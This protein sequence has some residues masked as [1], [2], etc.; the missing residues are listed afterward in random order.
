M[1][2]DGAYRH[3]VV[4]LEKLSI[5]YNLRS[6]FPRCFTWVVGKGQ[7]SACLTERIAESMAQEVAI[8]AVSDY[9]PAGI[10]I[11]H[12]LADQLGRYLPDQ[13]IN[14][15]RVKWELEHPGVVRQDCLEVPGTDSDDW[16]QYHRVPGVPTSHGCEIDSLGT[17]EIAS[18][19]MD[20]I[21]RLVG[22][23]NLARS[24][25]AMQYHG[26]CT[27]T[28]KTCCKTLKGTQTNQQTSK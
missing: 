14:T 23:N 8:V 7:P 18:L 2:R 20:E 13:A 3:V 21:E 10:N 26:S 19:V 9:D 1:C 24:L 27:K 15:I 22:P 16:I 11:A 6:M 25:L 17:Q 28:L 12:T 5:Y 4:Y